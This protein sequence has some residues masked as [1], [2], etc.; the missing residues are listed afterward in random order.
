A[1]HIALRSDQPVFADG[2]DVLPEV[3]RV[4]K[5]MERFSIAL[6]SGARKGYTGKMFTDIVNIG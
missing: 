3:Q 6:H 1:L 5:Q 2:V 4:L